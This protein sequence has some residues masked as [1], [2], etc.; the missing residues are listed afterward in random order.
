VLV[1]A[2]LSDTNPKH[3]TDKILETGTDP[4]SRA[5]EALQIAAHGNALLLVGEAGLA[6]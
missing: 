6:L 5:H 1:L 4:D 2:V 3:L